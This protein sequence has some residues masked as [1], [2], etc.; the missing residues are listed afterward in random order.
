MENVLLI[1]LSRQMALRREMDVIA[2]NVANVTTNGFKRRSAESREFQ[3]P[4]ASGDTFRRGADRRV[5]FV[6][7]R[8]TPLDLSTGTLERTGNPLDI[9]L[10]GDTWLVV[11]TP[12]GE[13]YT[14]NGA[15]MVNAQGQL[16]TS[17]GHPVV[18]E[19]GA[20]TFSSDETNLAITGD[21]TVSSSN[22]SRGRLRIVRFQNPQ[23]LQNAGANLFAST[24]PAQVATDARVQSGFI[25]RSNVR[26]VV[27]ISRMIEVTR[28]YQSIASLISRTDETRRTAIQRL[29]EPI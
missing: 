26:P 20:V 9:A 24:Q 17:D 8:G 25:E 16:V 29:G 28:Q 22:G 13:R 2:N 11:Q 12:Q 15:M 23:A 10:P 1:A 19:Q 18:G 5:S 21:G 27:E 4:V 3:M 6:V 7:D 14:R